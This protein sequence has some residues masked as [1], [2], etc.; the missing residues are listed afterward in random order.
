MM[1]RQRGEAEGRNQR[2][3]VPGETER[4]TQSMRNR[5]KERVRM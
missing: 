1:K 3:K 5:D 2:K 4:E